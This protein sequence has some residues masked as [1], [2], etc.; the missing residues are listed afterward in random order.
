ML[1]RV[2]NLLKNERGFASPEWLG[3]T[4]IAVILGLVVLN[5]LLP[6]TQALHNNTVDRITNITGSGF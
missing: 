5:A 3:L 6:K 4:V 1:S 2:K